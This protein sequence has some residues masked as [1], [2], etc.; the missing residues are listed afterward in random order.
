[1]HRIIVAGVLERGEEGLRTSVID[2]TNR[3][4]NNTKALKY[5]PVELKERLTALPLEQHS[6]NRDSAYHLGIP[7]NVIFYYTQKRMHQQQRIQFVQERKDQIWDYYDP[8]F[9]TIHIDVK[10]FHVDKKTRRGFWP[11]VNGCHIG[12]RIT[13]IIFQR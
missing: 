9:D 7:A 12:S 5:N 2:F 4:A 13:P 11:M 8:Q 6:T 1:V 3:R 10:N